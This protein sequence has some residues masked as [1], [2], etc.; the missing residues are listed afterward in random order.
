M[1]QD[2]D[3]TCSLY[4]LSYN[5]E[6]TRVAHSSHR[7]RTA[8]ARVGALSLLAIARVSPNDVPVHGT[9]RTS[10]HFLR[11]EI[12]PVPQSDAALE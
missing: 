7:S 9:K 2:L 3:S 11:P 12:G 6:P 8:A 10:Y 4:L 1:R 5:P